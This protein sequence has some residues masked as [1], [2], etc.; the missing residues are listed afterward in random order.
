MP[1]AN[2]H[3]A[4]VAPGERARLG[5]QAWVEWGLILLLCFVAGGAPAPHVNETHYLAKAKHYWNPLYCP[6]DLFLDSADAHLVFYWTLGW[7]TKYCSLSAVAWIGRLAGWFLIAAGWLSLSRAILPRRW[8]APAAALVWMVLLDK[9]DFSGEWV[10]GGLHGK[11][12]VE[13][14]VFAYG[15]LMFGLAALARGRWTAPWIWFG[16]ASALHALVGGWAVLAAGGVALT[17]P[18]PS[19]PRITV[20]LPGLVL[21][22]LL[23]L[24]GL[25]PALALDRGASASAA[26]EAARIYVFERLPHHLAPASLPTA[27]FLSRSLRFGLLVLAFAWLARWAGGARRP[28]R[29]GTMLAADGA[30]AHAPDLDALDRIIRFAAFAL[31]GSCLGLAINIAGGRFP[32]AAAPLLRYY[33]FRQADVMTPLAVALGSACFAAWLAER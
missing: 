14:K 22:G 8:A 2:Q 30:P 4:A 10:I 24:P 28:V 20:L 1:A 18:R 15:C 27:E 33:W 32:D 6:G 17:E 16:A 13:S 19:R 21:G 23:A 31:V 26:G 12:G 5:A 9:C 11:G 3:A 25:L 29:P 7:L